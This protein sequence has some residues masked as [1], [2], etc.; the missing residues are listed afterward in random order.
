MPFLKTD[1]ICIVLA[2]PIPVGLDSI[3]VIPLE[4]SQEHVRCCRIGI[5][6]IP[7]ICLFFVG[8][9]IPIYPRTE[10]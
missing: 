5:M 6:M 4:K 10:T 7:S 2:W 9:Q 1:D 8:A 3:F